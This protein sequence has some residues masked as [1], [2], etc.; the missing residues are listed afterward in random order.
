[1]DAVRVTEIPS[2]LRIDAALATS[3]QPSVDEL[4]AIRSDGTE[5][6]INLALHDDPR[7][8]L[9]D[10]AGTVS[11]LGMTYVH[12]PVKFDAPA[13]GDLVAFFEAME[14]HRGKKLL[15]HCA[16]NKRVTAFLGL[17]RVIREGWDTGRAFAPM[18][19]IWEPNA[20]WAPFIEAMLA[21][22]AAG[23][24]LEQGRRRE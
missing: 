7:Y 3:G 13:E 9:P 10:E 14:R 5:V 22:H 18:R 6:V 23:K 1:M 21:K 12:I 2:Y 19:E 24:R 8:S 11:A 4:H 17:Y 20:A 16:A 15:L